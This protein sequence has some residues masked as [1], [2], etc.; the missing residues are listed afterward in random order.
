MDPLLRHVHPLDAFEAEE[1]L[2][3]VDGRV[4]GDLLHDGP[5]S[6]LHVLAER[7][8]LDDQARQIYRYPLVRLKHAPSPKRPRRIAASIVYP[9]GDL[10]QTRRTSYPRAPA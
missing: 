1:E 4:G 5:N 8:P 2:D 6:L 7:D 3:L 10:A 9:A